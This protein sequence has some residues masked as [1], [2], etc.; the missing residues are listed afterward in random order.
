MMIRRG[1]ISCLLLGSVKALEKDPVP[2]AGE[3]GKAP[4]QAHLRHQPTSASFQSP[5]NGRKLVESYSGMEAETTMGV[6]VGDLTWNEIL[7]MFPYDP[8]LGT[9]SCLHEVSWCNGYDSVPECVDEAWRNPNRRSL[10]ER[11]K[12]EERLREVR[13]YMS[14]RRLSTDTI[15]GCH[16]FCRGLITPTSESGGYMTGDGKCYCLGGKS[17]CDPGAACGYTGGG[18]GR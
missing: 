18:Y 15:E 12:E 4:N 14:R 16:H 10:K 6:A 7:E 8:D 2:D 3:D 13:E 5:D 11:E 17:C 1:V 9:D